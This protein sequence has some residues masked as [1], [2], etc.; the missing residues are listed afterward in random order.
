M[1]TC[2]VSISRWIAPSIR[3]AYARLSYQDLIFSQIRP[4]KL[5]ALTSS[6]AIVS[7]T[8]L[9][10]ILSAKSKYMEKVN[11]LIIKPFPLSTSDLYLQSEKKYIYFFYRT[12][13][14]FTND[15]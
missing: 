5:R 15:N 10:D 8:R 7:H 1:D 4:H 11:K 6:W 2:A 14:I 12:I 3:L 9:D 13:S